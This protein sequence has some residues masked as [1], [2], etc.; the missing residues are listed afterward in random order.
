LLNKKSRPF[1]VERTAIREGPIGHVA[2]FLDPPGLGDAPF[3][4]DRDSHFPDSG[5]YFGF[6]PVVVHSVDFVVFLA[7][8]PPVGKETKPSCR[9]TRIS[10]LKQ[11]RTAIRLRL[12]RYGNYR[13]HHAQGYSVDN[14]EFLKVKTGHRRY[15]PFQKFCNTI[16]DIS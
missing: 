4:P 14:L 9:N 5:F 7:L 15:G 13:A 11:R 12:R 1:Q 10:R 6:G 8:H 2:G 16:L 3:A